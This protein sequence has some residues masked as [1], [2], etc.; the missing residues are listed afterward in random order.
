MI[1]DNNGFLD[2][3]KS[4]NMRFYTGFNVG[5]YFEILADLATY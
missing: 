2:L 4:V 3:L 1:D 5:S